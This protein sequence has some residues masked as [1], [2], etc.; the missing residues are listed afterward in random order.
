ML[1]LGK[2]STRIAELKAKV[3]AKTQLSI[4]G[5]V[6]KLDRITEF[7]PAQLVDADG[8]PIPVQKLPENV[9]K[10]IQELKVK[11]Y[12]NKDGIKSYVKHVYKIPSR[13]AAIDQ[14]NKHVGFYEL[15]N[16]QKTAQVIVYQQF[17]ALF[18]AAT[19]LLIQEAWR[20]QYGELPS[21]V[22]HG[23]D[24]DTTMDKGPVSA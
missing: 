8:F 11:E 5:Q 21:H 6:K 3:L 10:A 1:A 15:D 4:A 2:V 24:T 17:M 18:G 7:D 19:Q 13:V 16:A 22:D 14:E 20:A 23:G 12:F 9:R